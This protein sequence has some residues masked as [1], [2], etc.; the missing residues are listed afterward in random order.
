[1]ETD[2]SFS[3]KKIRVATSDGRQVFTCNIINF[4]RF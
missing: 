3:Q 1:M 4:E 2:K